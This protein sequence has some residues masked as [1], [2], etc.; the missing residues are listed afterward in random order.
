MWGKHNQQIAGYWFCFKI[1]FQVSDAHVMQQFVWQ[2]GPY[3]D[4]QMQNKHTSL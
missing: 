1:P 4:L 3:L 2:N